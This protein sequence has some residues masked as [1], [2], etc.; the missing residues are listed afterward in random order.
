MD[1]LE[2]AAGPG[3]WTQRI[4][5]TARSI[6]AT[7]IN[8]NTLVEARKKRYPEGK[9]S[10]KVADLYDLGDEPP[11]DGLFGG[12]IF[13]HIPKRDRHACIDTIN[14]YVVPGG[15]VALIDNNPITETDGV[16]AEGNQLRVRT[17]E[18]G[19]KHEIIKNY[20]TEDELRALLEGRA[21]GVSFTN[22]KYFWILTYRTLER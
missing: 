11:R 15:V 6:V 19:T 16:D 14:S 5:D 13:S 21:S 22:L 1:V 2:I 9:V 17:L 12:F 3:Y 8:E 10:F 18:D 20:P 7:D 4:A